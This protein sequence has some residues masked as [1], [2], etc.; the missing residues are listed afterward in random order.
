[1]NLGLDMRLQEDLAEGVIHLGPDGQ[2]TDFNRAATPWI[3]YANGAKSQLR[4]Q[5]QDIASGVLQPPVQIQLPHAADPALLDCTVHLCT[6][7]SNGYALFI[8]IRREAADA[9]LSSANDNDF[10]RLLGSQTRHELTHLR[11][12]LSN[13][14]NVGTTASASL[15]EESDRLSRLL[16]AFDQLSRLHQTDA[17]QT[18]ERLSLWRL[19]KQLVDEAPRHQC[20]FFITPQVES[21][22]ESESVIYGDARWL[23][24]SLRTLLVAIGESAPLHSSVEM[25]VSLS[26]GYITLSTHFAHS[27]SHEAQQRK[28]PVS[29]SDEAMTLDTDIG[30]HICQRVVEMHGGRLTI[31]ETDRGSNGSTGIESFEATFPL[32][33]P[34]RAGSSTACA[35]CPMAMQME[36]YAKDLAFLMTRQP[37]LARTSSQELQMLTKLLFSSSSASAGASGDGRSC[38][39]PP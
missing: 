19:V 28:D 34:S 18:G 22:T 31:H 29:S 33:A 2:V 7:G 4:Q 36:K 21:K 39:V 8:A 5:M 38:E 23:E 10:F 11:D 37:V 9:N 26:G 12:A 17:F 35:V 30:R 13:V 1:M 16:V 27:S 14:A 15:V 6:A 3:P 25:R 24:T 20:E 32:S